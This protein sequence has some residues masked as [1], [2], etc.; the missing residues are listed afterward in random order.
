MF[1]QYIFPFPTFH[2][3]WFL[4]LPLQN[5]S[6]K[7]YLFHK[8][9]RTHTHTH[10]HILTHTHTHICLLSCATGD[11]ECLIW[12]GYP[13]PL[14]PPAFRPLFLEDC[15]LLGQNAA[16]GVLLSST[17]DCLQPGDFILNIVCFSN[18]A[19]NIILDKLLCKRSDTALHI[20]HLIPSSYRTYSSI[21]VSSKQVFY[22][23][24]LLWNLYIRA[25]TISIK[26]L[27]LEPPNKFCCIQTKN[28]NW[29]WEKIDNVL[30]LVTN[31]TAPFFVLLPR[32]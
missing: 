21:T 25:Q 10:T 30:I 6:T 32:I 27:D 29:L 9:A 8:H 3:R 4:V 11:K 24:L 7:F 18:R 13:R 22:S 14:F 31:E 28:N 23:F 26:K 5:S 17:I 16:L 1:P 12:H 19:T 20:R 2:F 15:L